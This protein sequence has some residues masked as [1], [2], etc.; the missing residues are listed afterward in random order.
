MSKLTK[1]IVYNTVGQASTILLSFFAVKFIFGKLG[2]DV[3]GII[4]F[5]TMLGAFLNT[6]LDFGVTSTTMREVA[7]YHDSEPAYIHRL[8]QTGTLFYW[9]IFIILGLGIYFFSPMIVENWIN[10]STL[11]QSTAV[12]M[13]RILGIAAILVIPKSL[14]FGLFNGIERMDFT[15][16]IEVGITAFRQFSVILVLLLG[17]S[18]I[19]H[20]IYLYALS[21]I[22]LIVFYFLFA[23]RFFPIA[24]MMPGFSL[25]VVKR[26]INFASKMTLHTIVMTIYQQIDKL[27]ISKLMPIGILGY[28][29]F[30]YSNVGKAIFFQNSIVKAAYPS[31]CA[32]YGKNENTRLLSLFNKLQD[33][34]TY[35]IVPI[36]AAVPFFALP[37]FS[38]I[39]N[40]DVAR[41]LHLPI[42]LLT[43]GF[44]L[45]GTIRMPQLF[46]TVI[47]KPEVTVKANFYS[48]FIIL[49]IAAVLIYN[50]GLIGA[51]I[52]YIARII[53]H[54]SY[55]IPQYYK[56]CLHI[57]VIKFYAHVSRLLM[58]IAGSYMTVWLIVT[59]FD[60]LSLFILIGGYLIASTLYLIG[61]YFMIGDEMR[62]RFLEFF[63]LKC[64]LHLKKSQVEYQSVNTDIPERIF[65]ADKN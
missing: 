63:R 6:A 25:T 56:K 58:L 4:F 62:L 9:T 53:F 52:A 57:P 47:N 16:F 51:G 54:Y 65:D 11:S 48:L 10:L 46:A 17:S 3:L 37:F 27:I 26:N 44:F 29:S 42:T 55:T 20:V 43:F 30:A 14:Y 41:L 32:L 24:A 45:Y 33:M 5:T 28:Y 22:L 21:Y 49:P 36:L 40:T 1:N 59:R 64:S 39:F 18:D 8:I 35:S 7:S 12:K 13:L 61:G 60:N 23:L 34:I 19:F 15:N 38:Y 2:A 50:F 31:L